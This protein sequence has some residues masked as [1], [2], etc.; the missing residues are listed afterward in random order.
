[1]LCYPREICCFPKAL[2]LNLA[3]CLSPRTKLSDEAVD[4]LHNHN[5]IEAEIGKAS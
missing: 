5:N 4:V 2:R 3:L 1:M